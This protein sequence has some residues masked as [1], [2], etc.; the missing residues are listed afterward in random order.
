MN[1][2]IEKITALILALSL[3]LSMFTVNMFVSA[4]EITVWD[5]NTTEP[6][7]IDSKGNVLISTPQELAYIVETGGVAGTNYKLT[8]DIYLNEI[9][10]VNWTTGEVADGYT[11]KKWYDSIPFKGGTIDGDGHVVYGLY[12]LKDEIGAYRAHPNG[13][14]LIPRLD[15]NAN[16]T[17]NNLGIENAYVHHQDTAAAFLG[18][19]LGGNTVEFNDC[20]ASKTVTL[21]G[22]SAGVFRGYAYKEVNS[23][24]LTNCYSLASTTGTV[25]YGLIGSIYDKRPNLTF[26]NCYN[27][28]GPL[29]YGGNIGYFA[30]A[31][32]SY[33]TA[34][35]Q[36]STGGHI[37]TTDIRITAENMQGTDALT[38]SSKMNKLGSGYVATET[39]PILKVF[40]KTV[41]PEEPE[42]PEVNYD[43][44]DRTTAAPSDSDSDGWI[45]ITN[46][47]ELAYIVVNGGGAGNKYILTNDIY[48]NHPDKVDWNTGAKN[49][50][51]YTINNWYDH[52]EDFQGTINGNGH[53]I[54]GLY[55]NSAGAANGLYGSGLIPKASGAV[56]INNL[57][58]EHSYINSHSVSAFVAVAGNGV[59][60]NISNCY[61]GSTV[62]LVAGRDA[63]ALAGRIQGYVTIN[64]CYSLASITG[65]NSYGLLG[66][67]W[68][69]STVD[70]SFNANG[71]ISYGT[72]TSYFV[73]ANSAYETEKSQSKDGVHVMKTPTV[74]TSKQMEGQSTVMVLGEDFVLTDSYP[75]LKVF[76][77]QRC[78]HEYDDE[79]DADCNKCGEKRDVPERPLGYDVWDGQKTA[80]D[81]SDSDGI[82]EITNGAELAY[83]IYNG[84]SASNRYIL[85]NDIYLNNLSKINWETGAVEEGYTVNSWFDHARTFQGEING[86][87]YVIYGLYFNSN[88]SSHSSGA[89][90]TGLIPKVTD[91]S[92]VTIKNLGMAN[93]Y[94]DHQY[95]TSAFVGAAGSGARVDID[96]CYAGENVTL[97]G[98]AAGVFRGFARLAAGGAIT[99]CYS[100]ATTNGTNF[101]GLIGE[102]WDDGYEII[103]SNCFNVKGGVSTHNHT[104]QINSFDNYVTDN[105]GLTEGT[106][107]LTKE[108]MQGIGAFENMSELNNNNKFVITTKYPAL[109]VFLS[110]IGEDDEETDVIEIWN[111]KHDK[112]PVDSN[113]DGIY[114]IT[115][116]EELA[117]VIATGNASGYNY[118]L[119]KDIYLNDIT[120]VNWKTGQVAE[121]YTVNKWFDEYWN[122][123]NTALFQGGYIN[124]NGH[125][126][127]G[128]YWE[129]N[130]SSYDENNAGAGL[131]PVIAANA[132]ETVIKNLGIDYAYVNHQR[133]AS[134]F[135]GAQRDNTVLTIDSCYAG[136]N[137][138]LKAADAGVFR[139]YARNTAGGAITNCYSLATVSGTVKHGLIAMIWDN[140]NLVIENC[141]NAN[142]PI[143]SHNNPGNVAASNNYESYDDNYNGTLN[144]LSE[145]VTSVY[146]AYMQGTDV[147]T[148]NDK[149]SGINASKYVAVT[150]DY[151]QLK[152]FYNLSVSKNG[153][154]YI[155]KQYDDVSSYY[156]NTADNSDYFWRYNKI[157]VNDDSK[158]DIS[159]LV[160]MTLLLN[161]NKDTVDIDK[162]GKT[163]HKDAEILRLALIGSAD[164]AEQ[165]G[166]TY[167]INN[168]NL[169]GVYSYV[170]GDEFDGSGVNTD[171][172]SADGSVMGMRGGNNNELTVEYTSK[173]TSVENGDLTLT[174]YKD[175]DG[176][177]HVPWSVN[178]KKTMNYKYGY[179]EIRAKLPTE[180][181][182]FSSFWTR[183]VSD[184]TS[185]GAC[186]VEGTLDHYAEVDMFEIFNVASR[187]E[188]NELAGNIL[189]N[190][191]GQDKGWYGSDMTN[192]QR[193]WVPTDGEYHI[194]GYEWTPYEINLYIDGVKYA[195]FDITESWTSNKTDGKGLDGWN[196][197]FK[198]GSKAIDTTGTG[199]E[200]FHEAQYIIFNNHLHYEGVFTAGTSVTKNETYTKADFAIDYCRVY[201]AKGQESLVA[202]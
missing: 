144:V 202:K 32:N 17:I 142:G 73:K 194:Y 7:N 178:T 59:A 20:Y 67:I 28:T 87:G 9:D 187:G 15:T 167:K 176:S 77:N 114:E 118:I 107:V 45:E 171:K 105:T 52:A 61:A 174:S 69:A 83:A 136:T 90:G 18:T 71:P 54:H 146:A 151:P 55:F 116:G 153:N 190:F 165:F 130:P 13:S 115:N 64:S 133:S 128:L 22:G 63:G 29:G 97:K 120:M 78:D 145:G 76:T 108:Q 57:G 141:Y 39:Y 162:D 66:D 129:G 5:G 113:S 16:L 33:A 1:K 103:V 181:G 82:Y 110:Y 25:N 168:S 38:N 104:S 34:Q 201:Q 99:N 192:A 196:L 75:V 81:D 19:A 11:V 186:L 132:D 148:N 100:L 47:K 140:T 200:S 3:L 51:S 92:S 12:F 169:S 197:T 88:P 127:Y 183:S 109:K 101:N 94:L 93:V 159:D 152:S 123:G 49:D 180:V 91:N 157:L 111:G 182:A 102:V 53:I 43:V 172:W 173:S 26:N 95:A 14:G 189:K 177:Y 139:G 155:G 10:K 58:V 137:V 170:W 35:S 2:R 184:N 40:S 85:T 96:S 163:T 80:P 147:F 6:T 72:N 188:N 23:T 161:R 122:K 158:M 156:T 195:R 179:V 166:Q 185:G 106:T 74:I 56:T 65:A 134:A 44:W 8:A 126:V 198:T 21:I 175:T 117:W 46:G 30:V 24:A 124:G 50:G 68:S 138:T 42:T 135:V 164:Y 36:N 62:T 41:V 48:L 98:F 89:Y 150:D 121:G 193:T 31:T 149:M 191:P 119:T 154:N 4:E 86:N 37:L 79:Y 27:A 160:Y 199:M 70:N 60:I 143:S 131:I 112:A 84:G 125:V